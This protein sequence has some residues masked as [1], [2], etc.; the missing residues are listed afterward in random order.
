MLLLDVGIIVSD[1]LS[2]LLLSFPFW[3]QNR[4]RDIWFSFN[5]PPLWYRINTTTKSNQS[6]RF[7]IEKAF[8]IMNTLCLMIIWHSK[9]ILCLSIS[10]RCRKK[11]NLMINSHE[12]CSI[13]DCASFIIVLI[14]FLL[15][16]VLCWG[17]ED[18]WQML[19][20][21]PGQWGLQYQ[22]WFAVERYLSAFTVC[23]GGLCTQ[24]E[25]HYFW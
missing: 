8:I 11:K 4:K 1:Q 12:L 5:P 10:F 21:S 18:C 22:D 2:I 19:S 3:M 14:F 9:K 15:R 20:L 7:L 17:F 25:Q 6:A 13:F 16:C 24:H 23:L